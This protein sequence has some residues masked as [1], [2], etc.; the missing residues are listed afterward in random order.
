MN[1]DPNLAKD[2]PDVPADLGRVLDQLPA[3]AAELVLAALACSADEL[4][5]WMTGVAGP[6]PVPVCVA[7]TVTG[8]SA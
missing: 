6:A 4:R 8:I 7:T 3:E 2:T 1:T 5:D